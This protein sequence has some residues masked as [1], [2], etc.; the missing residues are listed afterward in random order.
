MSAL[1]HWRTLKRFQLMSALPPKADIPERQGHVRFVPKADIAE[2]L[3]H[4]DHRAGR[5]DDGVSC[6][7]FSSLSSS[8]A[9]SV[10]EA[11]MV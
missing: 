10:I 2:K 1:G 3:V 4:S 8:T 6:L 11:V 9:S 5:L 7:A